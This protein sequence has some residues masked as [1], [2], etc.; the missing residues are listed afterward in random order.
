[1]VVC[2]TL[3]LIL[4][5]PVFYLSPT[6]SSYFWWMV[7]FF[8]ATNIHNV[9]MQYLKG[10]G[11][12]AEYSIMGVLATAITLGANVLFLLCFRWGLTGYFFATTLSH[13]IISMLIVL[14]NQ[15]WREVVLPKSIQ[16]HVWTDVV[17]FSLPM[18]PNSVSWWISN[19]S[20]RYMILGF[21]SSAA[22][23]LY[24]VA[25]KVPTLLTMFMSLFVSAFQLSVFSEHGS[26]ETKEFFNRVYQW[27][28]VLILAIA[29]LL[30]L[31]SEYMAIIL[32]KNEFFMAWK[33][34]CILIL[35]FVF[36]SLSSVLGTFYTA[37]KD[38]KK[39]LYSTLAAALVN[40][41]LNFVLIPCMGVN[42]AAIATFV[43]YVC[44][45]LIRMFH[46]RKLNYLKLV[47]LKVV[48]AFWLLTVQVFIE[49]TT[50]G[51]KPVSYLL[52]SMIILVL[53]VDKENINLIEIVK[54]KVFSKE[55]K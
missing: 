49:V 23:G 17:R 37:S 10:I 5:F 40:V 12:V 3:I 8:F 14:R 51:L 52:S 36:N 1:M 27:S 46:L 54:A 38:T 30:V 39:L 6:L 26:Q 29:S 48:L 16:R 50:Y 42:G 18:I 53:F 47:S 35:A 32:Y 4:L 24:S 20:D 9:L 45:W 44:V 19:S 15:L 25:Y 2:G 31:T 28:S 7:A 33:T 11:K 34:G 21:L 13:V 22:V 55:R 43:S 41:L